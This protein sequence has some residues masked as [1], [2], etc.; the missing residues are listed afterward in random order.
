MELL[1]LPYPITPSPLGAF[2]AVGTE[3]GIKGD[4]L[5]LLLTNPGERVMMPSFGTPLRELIF[6]Q[7]TVALQ[8]SAKK[9]ILDSIRN[10]E[11][12]IVVRS[13][14]VTNTENGNPSLLKNSIEDYQ[15]NPYILLIN[16]QYSILTNIQGIQKLILQ[17]PLAGGTNA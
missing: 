5:Q 13:L 7:N 9:M 15:N 16:L 3:V 8:D 4:L 17:V 12:R 1:A 14:Q 10:W 2:R 11:P 6:Q